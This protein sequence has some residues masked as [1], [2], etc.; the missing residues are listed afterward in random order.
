[1]QNSK[2]SQLLQMIRTKT[3]QIKNLMRKVLELTI[4][5]SS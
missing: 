5:L 4:L 3:V 1:M 2:L